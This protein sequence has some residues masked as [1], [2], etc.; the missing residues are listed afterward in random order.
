M[1]IRW[2]TQPA[3]RIRC[4]PTLAVLI[5][6]LAVAPLFGQSAE[7]D[8]GE[9]DGFAGGALGA[10][11]RGVVG[12]GAG[13]ALSRHGVAVLEGMYMP[14]GREI[15]WRRSDIQRPQDSYLLNLGLSFQIRFPVGDRWA[16]YGIIG[17]GLLY[18]AYRAPAGT[19]GRLTD[20]QDF[21]G[22]FH[23]GAG[24]RYYVGDKW[25]IRPEVRVIISSRTFTAVSVGV[26]YV[27]PSNWP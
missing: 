17:S 8:V 16:P 9:V 25:G 6:G 1:S 20:M 2:D 23:T 4:R 22:E 18:N 21:K 13:V 12:A 5:L 7:E 10:G 24:L 3:A 26:F 27:L 15:L 19:A 11:S 14:L